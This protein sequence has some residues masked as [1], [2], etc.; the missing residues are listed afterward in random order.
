MNEKQ[1]QVLSCLYQLRVL[2]LE[3]I[4]E[5]F[6][7]TST[8]KSC[9]VNIHKSLEANGYVKREKKG[10]TSYYTIADKGV[11][12]LKKEG[13]CFIGTEYRPMI[14]SDFLPVS[15][16]VVKPRLFDHQCALNSFVLNF[17]K[18]NIP[19][20]WSY[21]DEKFSSSVSS[22][23]R[24]DG[25]LKVEDRYF[26]LEMDM[27]TE[28]E[29][30]LISKWEHYR[31]FLRGFDKTMKISVLFLVDSKSSEKRI[32]ELRDSMYLGL[33]GKIGKTFDAY[34]FTPSQAATFLT[35]YCY[36]T[37]L[38]PEMDNRVRLLNRRFPE[39]KKKDCLTFVTD[40]AIFLDGSFLN[41]ALI[42]RLSTF[43]SADRPVVVL[44]ATL[45]DIK[46]F[47]RYDIDTFREG[48]YFSTLE[49]IA[50]LPFFKALTWGGA[51]GT[52]YT[53]VDNSFSHGTQD[54][55]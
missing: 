29:K 4:Q 36:D 34:F 32:R 16:I 53:M 1:K 6:Y 10:H 49:R 3:Q 20:M 12:L 47:R 52:I 48:L 50:T 17:Q 19:V 46:A 8:P 51:D 45:D 9:M 23:M 11:D 37:I 38:D 30:A 14:Q 22:T 54:F 18:A 40:E 5:A 41:L 27:D 21:Y 25:I 55:V 31:E 35:N 44:L 15:K 24:P 28:R 33:Y 13:I 43:K 42:K 2:T 39:V 7:P 26:F